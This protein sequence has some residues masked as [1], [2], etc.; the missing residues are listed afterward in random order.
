MSYCQWKQGYYSP[1]TWTDKGGGADD[2]KKI[3][4]D[5]LKDHYDHFGLYQILFFFIFSPQTLKL[6]T[7]FDTNQNL[8]N[9]AN[10]LSLAE[11]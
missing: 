5:V 1:S 4:F 7:L 10:L 6:F 9:S 3:R 2:I 11:N 8:N